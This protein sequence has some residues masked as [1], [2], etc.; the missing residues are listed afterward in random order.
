M[1]TKRRNP[2]RQIPSSAGSESRQPAAAVVRRNGLS[3]GEATGGEWTAILLAVAVFLAPAL[4]VPNEL[5]LQD[6]LKSIVV[7]FAALGAGLL[8][9]WEQ[10]HRAEPLRWHAVMWLPLLLMVYALVSM[11]W[12]HSYLAG[13]ETIRWFIFSLLLWLG[14]NTLSR[15]R[16]PMLA[17]A[18]HGGAVV[19]AL[20]TALQFWI[21][22]RFFPQGPN[23]ASTFVNRN[24]FAEFAVCTLP[25]GALLLA[26]ARQ[27]WSIALL[28]MSSGLVIVSILMTGTRS[29]L[30]AMWLQLLVLFPLAAWLYRDQFAFRSWDR[31]RRGLAAGLLLVMVSGL[32]SIPSG[33]PKIQEEQRGANAL[34]RGF[35]RTG[36]ISTADPSLGVRMVM[37]KATI[38]M[39]EARPLSG[40]GA[41]AWENEI[42]LYQEDGSQLETDYY[43]H[44]EFLQLIAEYGLVGWLFLLLLFAYLV[45]A[46]W[47][48]LA[49][50]TPEGRAEGPFRVLVLCSLLTL[51]IVSNV[52]FPWRMAATGALFAACLAMLAASDARSGKRISFGAMLLRWKPAYSHAGVIASLAGLALAAYITQQAAESER[53]I[54]RATE[55]ALTISA[56]G[57]P[58][59][60]RWNKRK[61]ELLQLIREGTAINPHYR[62]IT[63]IVA[64]ELARWGDWR[65]ATWIWESVLSSRPYI[66]AIMTNVARGYASTGNPAKALEYLDRAK[67]IQPNAPAVRSLEVVLLSRTGQEALALEL[68]RQAIRTNVADFDL[69][70]ATFILATRAGDFP[71]ARKAMDMRIASRTDSSVQGYLQLG[72]MYTS[73]AHEP[74]DA[75]QS[76]RQAL[77]LTPPAARQGV[78]TQI[79]PEFWNRLGLTG[80]M[81]ATTTQMSVISK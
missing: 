3:A 34:E 53:K 56:S 31:A 70:N 49:D 14:L 19:A 48:T 79:P 71:L 50:Q 37:W 64:D 51:F 18:I 80:S 54:V 30:A 2:D 38:R 8:F 67:K 63:P 59:N 74:E 46:A 9:F 39:I 25:F 44:N 22:F 17:W 76:F 61:A 4:G 15:E 69:L 33:N 10:R 62:K 58:R 66:V 29:A 32:G 13:V 45:A 16:L 78:Q 27:R 73:A 12:S 42:P 11:D 23:P 36:S 40:V 24:F 7:A 75:L 28:A 72:N 57:D 68:A 5:M 43:V 81:P 41:G 26:R 47:R 20:W 52:G 6:T 55:L 35:G 60:P 77:E 1:A 21:D 65:D